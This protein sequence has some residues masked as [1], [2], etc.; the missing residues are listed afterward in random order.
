MDSIFGVSI[1]SI[2]NVLI[3]VVAVA[4]VWLV[5]LVLRRRVIFTIGVRNLPRRPAQTILIVVGLML[6]TLVISAAR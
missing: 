6:S 1:D 3:A 2:L 5:R 4:L